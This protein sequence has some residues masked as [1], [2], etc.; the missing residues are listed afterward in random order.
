MAAY[1]SALLM[2]G[3]S[4]SLVWQAIEGLRE[5]R[6]VAYVEAMVVAALGLAVSL[7]VRPAAVALDA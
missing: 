3:G 1:S 6:S 7:V 5:P 4:L 2:L